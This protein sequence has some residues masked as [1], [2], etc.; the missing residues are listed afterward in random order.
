MVP[1]GGP[2]S[3]EMAVDERSRGRRKHHVLVLC[4]KSRL[5]SK[6]DFPNGTWLDSQLKWEAET[7]R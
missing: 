4:S 2:S 3:K 1:Q 5:G 7:P 6:V